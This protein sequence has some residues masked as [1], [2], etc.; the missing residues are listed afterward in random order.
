MVMTGAKPRKQSQPYLILNVTLLFTVAGIVNMIDFN[1]HNLIQ[2]NHN[3]S[4][5]VIDSL[6]N[7]ENIPNQYFDFFR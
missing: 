6:A 7:S 4:N 2:I 3:F 5:F 1:S